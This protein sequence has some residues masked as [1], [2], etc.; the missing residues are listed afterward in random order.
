MSVLSTQLSLGLWNHSAIINNLRFPAS[1]TFLNASE[2]S[3]FVFFYTDGKHL[4]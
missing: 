4:P 1:V 2:C 3:A